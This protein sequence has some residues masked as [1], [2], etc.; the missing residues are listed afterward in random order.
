MVLQVIPIFPNQYAVTDW[1]I[2]VLHVVLLLSVRK[3]VAQQQGVRIAHIF[4]VVF[5]L[6]R[7]A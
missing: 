1:G 6:I 2:L 5:I 7:F 4:G 3:I